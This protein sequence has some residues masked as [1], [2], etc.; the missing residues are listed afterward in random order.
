M[1]VLGSLQ[2]ILNNKRKLEGLFTSFAIREESKKNKYC[3]PLFLF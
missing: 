1:E 3:L 2:R